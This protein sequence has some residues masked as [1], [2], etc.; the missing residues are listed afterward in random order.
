MSLALKTPHFCQRRFPPMPEELAAQH[1]GDSGVSIAR[2]TKT[3]RTRTGATHALDE[4]TRLAMNL[5]LMRFWAMRHITAVLVTHSISEAVLLADR[6]VV[7]MSSGSVE[8]TV[9]PLALGGITLSR[10]V[11]AN[12]VLKGN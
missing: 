8:A 1:E 9:R 10:T 6:I 7:M 12:T 4:M 3:Y 11:F 5:E 2:V